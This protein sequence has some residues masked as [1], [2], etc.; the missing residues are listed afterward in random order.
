MF[1]C[2]GHS[3]AWLFYNRFTVFIKCSQSLEKATAFSHFFKSFKVISLFSYQGSLLLFQIHSRQTAFVLYQSFHCLSRTFL[4]YFCCTLST[5]FSCRLRQL[6]YLIIHSACCQHPFSI[7]LKF[8]TAAQPAI[9]QS[10]DNQPF[11]ESDQY[12]QRAVH[13]A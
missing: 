3:K 9:H 13:A 12:A 8:Y 10:E 7:F 11:K 6:V 4:I 5:F 1:V 2:L